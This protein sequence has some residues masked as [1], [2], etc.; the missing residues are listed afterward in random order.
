MSIESGVLVICLEIARVTNE[1]FAMREVEDENERRGTA[2]Y[3]FDH[4]VWSFC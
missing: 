4:K 1:V 3:E 2:L